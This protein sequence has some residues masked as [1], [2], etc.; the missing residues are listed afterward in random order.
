[1]TLE[2]LRIFIAVAE[3]EHLTR[4]AEAIRLTPSA[5]SAAIKALEAHYRVELFHRIGR[6][7]ELTAEGAVF[8]PEA[9]AVLARLRQA[10][11]SLGEL[12]GLARGTLSIHASQTVASYWLPPLLMAFHERFPGIAL[13]MVI[14]N[15]A[16]VARAVVDGSADIGFVEGPLDEPALSV[17][18]IARDRLAVVVGPRHPWAG[19]QDLSMEQLVG[20]SGWVM[21]EPG[22]GTRAAFED[23]LRAAGQDPQALRI[24]LEFPSNE[25]VLSAVRGGVCAA[26]V[27]ES[28]AATAL[29]E[30]SLLRAYAT[31]PARAFSVLY[32]KER[33]QSRAAAMLEKLARESGRQGA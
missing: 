11:L 23:A 20:E 12:A 3:R 33:R 6:R 22:S 25:A 29:R 5:V 9:R 13:S 28:A 26:A 4:A 7:I 21:R 15:T 1:M 19:G 30:G 18:E 31:L 14:G 24:V 17:A 10:E 16:T 2:Q 27:S 32:H 8:L